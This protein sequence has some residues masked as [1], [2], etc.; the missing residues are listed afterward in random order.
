MSAQV[1]SEDPLVPP[2]SMLFDGTSSPEQFKTFG[3]NF[4]QYILVQRAQLT[5]SASFLEVV[6]PAKR[7][8]ERGSIRP[9]IPLDDDDFGEQAIPVCQ[10]DQRVD[11]LLGTP[12]RSLA[13][14]RIVNGEDEADLR[15]LRRLPRGCGGAPSSFRSSA[16]RR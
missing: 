4:L 11:V 14:F 8:A 15:A 1:Q 3:E 12:E 2:A 13:V 6:R 9:G 10:L 16:P 7:F 5:P